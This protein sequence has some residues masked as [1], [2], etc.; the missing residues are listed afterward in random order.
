M[1]IIDDYSDRFFKEISNAHYAV[2]RSIF[3]YFKSEVIENKINIHTGKKL[4]TELVK[5]ITKNWEYTT[6]YDMYKESINIIPSM[7]FIYEMSCTEALLTDY[8]KEIYWEK[9]KK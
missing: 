1:S 8:I 6:E 2:D 4:D 7:R 9:K 5:H 3:D